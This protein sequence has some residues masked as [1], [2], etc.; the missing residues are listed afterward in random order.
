LQEV[1]FNK[2][3]NRFLKI[4]RNASLILLGLIILLIVLVNLSPVQNFV[5]RKVTEQLSKKLN[6]T[7]GL[8]NVRID[9][10]NHVLLEGLY[11]EDHAHD[12]VLYAGEARLR[13]TDWFIFRKETPVLHYVGLHN[14]YVHLYRKSISKDWN[15]QF[16]IDA[17]DTGPSTTKKD[18]GGGQI[19]LDLKKVDLQNVRFHMD[20]AWVGSDMEINVGSFSLNA[21]D[22]DLK[23]RILNLNDVVARN[24]DVIFRDY[25]GGRPPRP[26]KI[27]LIDTTA[28]NPDKW[29]IKANALSLENC[30]FSR[31]AA[32][33]PA[34]PNEFDPEHIGISNIAIEAK[35][36]SIIGDTIT[37]K[38]NN[39][40]ARERSGIAIRKM[41]ADVS[42]SPN[43]SICNNL[44]LETN[45]SK[46]GH[47]YAM[48]YTRFPDFEQ[49]IDKV[50]MEAKLD[51]SI[52]DSRDVA[53]FAPVLRKYPTVLKAS[54][55]F[56]GS[57][58]SLVGNKIVIADGGNI[59]RGNLRMI[60]LPDIYT[61]RIEFSE[62]EIYTSGAAIM[63]YAP[64]LRHN[65]N[66]TIGN[67]SHAY[68]KGSFTGYIENFAANGTLTTNLG[69]V[70]SDVK[71]KM[72]GLKGRYSAYSGTV[73]TVNFNAGALFGQ[74]DLGGLTLHANISG[75][76]F[77]PKK[78]QVKINSVIDKLEYRGYTYHNIHADGLLAKNNFNGNVLVDDPNLALAFYGDI[79]LNQKELSIN[80]KANLL[81]S[82]LTALKLTKDSVQASADFDMNWVGNNIDDFLG[83]AKLYNINLV[84]NGHRL[85]L[86][87]ISMTSSIEKEEKFIAINSNILTANIKGKFLLSRLPYS[88]QFYVS[89]YL[90]NYI[91]APVKYAPDQVISFDITTRE[92]DSLL[93]VV[94]PNVKGFYNTTISG[95]LNMPQ[96]KLALNAKIPYGKIAN[97]R[98]GN[99]NITGDGNFNVLALNMDAEKI[100][101]GDSMLTGSMSVTTTLGN[102]SLLFNIATTSPD[103]FGTSTL[104][105]RAIAKGDSLFLTLLPSSFFFNHNK[106]EIPA[107]S[108]ITFSDKYLFVKDLY[109]RS[110]DQ[111]IN[112]Y[113][114]N[115]NTSQSLAI[116]VKN[117]D[118]NLF[119][120]IKGVEDYDP[121]GRINGNITVDNLFAN[122]FVRADIKA[123]DVR[124]GNDTLGN[125]NIAGSYDT[126]KNIVMLDGQ[127]GVYRGNSSITT[128]G[129][130]VLFDSTSKQ[131]LNGNIQF[132]NTPITWI[133]PF[134]QGYVSNIEGTL[135]GKV[136]I[137]GTPYEPDVDG[138][139][140]MNNASL[141]IDFLGTTYTI[142]NASITVDNKE[143]NF[144]NITLY[145]SYKNTA[146]LN[147]KISHERFN[148]MQ[149][150]ISATSPKFEV[151]NL[152]D[153][154]NS[155]FYGN[156]I[157]GF[158][159]FTA[160]GPFDDIT[161]RITRAVPADKSHLYLPIGSS[162]AGI[163]TYSYVS[164]KSYDTVKKVVK[165]RNRNKL[166]IN[167]DSRLNELCEITM[168]LDPASG[169][170]INA[171]GT[172]NLNMEI[173]LGNDIRMYGNY[174][175]SEGDYLFTLRQLLI[176]KRFEL[177]AGS[178]ISFNGPIA[179]T[180][181][182]IDG[183][184]KA[185]ARLYDMLSVDEKTIL[186]T[187]S[188]GK[189][190]SDRENLA[191]K[192]TLDINVLLH[193]AGSLYN[194]QLTFKLDL[195]DKHGIGTVAYNRV[196]YV[197]QHTDQLF[198]EVAALLL[199]N[200]FIPTEDI[201]SIGG[202]ATS[203]AISNFSDMIS[204]TASS[205]L[206]NVITK[207]TGNK[208]IALDLKY[209]SYSYTGDEATGTG[210]RNVVS[211]AYRQSFF[212]DRLSI[213]LGGAYDWGKP[214]TTSSTASNVTGDFRAE[215]QVKEG[216][217]LRLNFFR[218][219][220]YDVLV[221]HNISRSGM[222]ISWRKSFDTFGEFFHGSSYVKRQEDEKKKLLENVKEKKNGTD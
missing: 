38:L 114:N 61:T 39:L 152:K 162:G 217:N 3:L 72:P 89:G 159:S 142:P 84:R 55:H 194:P 125:V 211:T 132:N 186:K 9:F 168:V 46:L 1:K 218:T 206:T 93:G 91:K 52:I 57:V 115:T 126:K 156:L 171:K 8:K 47:Y 116:D 179:Q 183:V 158:Q 175:I 129:Q 182:N 5:A 118:V 43:A 27:K 92:I 215:W 110:G 178:R 187:I 146:T 127:S 83:F 210:S 150:N 198:N 173:P 7:V 58:D 95:S 90:P 161:M 28:F 100:I 184:Y 87:S 170:A 94:L 157:A 45:H 19:E 104:N 96:Q 40:S 154:E 123:T 120:A 174:E 133:S 33:R 141:K 70:Y 138:T 151:I 190:S 78:A 203:T 6:T 181:M 17:F 11:I 134:V 71:L 197:N 34:T 101:I 131:H 180:D 166:N 205:Q 80:A 12:T 63:K 201:G 191:A 64:E 128:S 199:I 221:D 222:G 97:V 49:Y 169:D 204:S 67:I 192:S 135:N 202:G 139:V 103:A 163:S 124:L 143:I 14:A 36:I 189:E 137:A 212:N 24:T 119:D 121:Q 79:D 147:G 165:K 30:L 23:K 196:D 65:P 130:L 108:N 105:G 219:S 88:A 48:R 10:L 86:D 109:I 136:N 167:I 82:D 42:V 220:N 44:Y 56:A 207:I 18:T 111:Q 144:G 31:D 145:D 164:F 32:L 112:A 213:Q 85:D 4:L 53:Y 195:P 153:N 193:M 216:G 188:N 209:K 26:K 62:G 68:F 177:N 99:V 81:K 76:G 69:S 185:R 25:E 74:S 16:I 214:A 75:T 2:Q 60:G 77:D 13:I 155:T 208:D 102:D 21:N 37:A 15:Y 59:I 22:I 140:A 106:W 98:F 35:N 66:F 107:G 54:G 149:L 200:S 73:S 122:T 51:N 160:R 50:V 172:G 41:S 29:I 148:K 176:R 113:S 117:V 20:D